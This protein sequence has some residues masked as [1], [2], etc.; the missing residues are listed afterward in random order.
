MT[1]K[2]VILL[3]FLFS[4]FT[5]GSS[6]I[7]VKLKAEREERKIITSKNRD[8]VRHFGTN[9]FVMV[10]T[11]YEGLDAEMR[12]VWVATVYNIAIS[13]QNGNSVEDI[14][15]YQKEFLEILDRMEEYGMNTLFFQV[16]PANDAFYQ[17]NLNPW[18]KFLV[19]EGVEP[20]WDPLRFMI[21]ETHKRGFRFYCWMNAFRVTTESYVTSGKA[22][23]AKFEDIVKMKHEALN[24]LAKDNFARLHPEYVVAG[25]Y[26]EKLILNPSE[27]MV[28][29]FIVDTIME[30]VENYDVDGLHFDDYFYLDG[31]SSS[32]TENTCFVGYNGYTKDGADILNDIPNY[33][34]YQKNPSSYGR[35][36]FGDGGIYGMEAGLNLGD[37]RRENI[38]IMMRN[39]RQKIDA[40]NQRTKKRVEFGTKPA[41]V[42]RSNSEYCTPG[43]SRCV[44]NG[45]NTA[46][47]AYS[48]YNDL[49]ADS[50]KW[51]QEGLVDWVAPQVYYSFEDAYAPYADIVDWWAEQ[52]RIINEKRKQ[53]GKKDIRLY[54]AQGIYK[55][56]DNPDQFYRSAEIIDQLKYNNKY[57]DVLKGSAVYSY[58]I[59]Y[60]TLGSDIVSKYPNAE[61]I[62]K[63]AMKNFKNLWASS[64]VFPLAI[65]ENDATNLVLKEYQIIENSKGMVTI[66]FKTLENAC[67]YGYY[68]VKKGETF[69]SNNLNNRQAVIYAGYEEN[70]VLSVE[71]GELDETFDYYFIPVSVN[72]Y[73]ATK[74]TKIDFSQKE[75]NVAPNQTNLVLELPST[76]EQLVGTTIKGYF[77]KPT[78]NNLDEVS[79]QFQ[80]LE[81]T[82]KRSIDVLTEEKEDRI[83]FYW[84]SYYYETDDLQIILV[85]SDGDLQTECYS[86]KFRLVENYSPSQTEITTDKTEYKVGETIKVNYAPLT[87]YTNLTVYL[88]SKQIKIDITNQYQQTNTGSSFEVKLT[89]ECINNCFIEFQLKNNTKTTICQSPT[90]QVLELP[91]T[92]VEISVSNTNYEGG[93]TISVH[94][95][96]ID[97]GCTVRV[98]L[99]MNSTKQDMTDA[100]NQTKNGTTFIIN[101]P[102]ETGDACY[103]EL[104]ITNQ[105]NSKTF[106]S[107]HFSIEK[108][109]GKNCK[110]CQKN[111]IVIIIQMITFV[112]IGIYAF[113]KRGVL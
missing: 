93:S 49:Y 62:R 67:C 107:P 101:L 69:D 9:Q 98:Y 88:V 47:G 57:Q 109:S 15:T 26:D 51:V 64:P 102:N 18:S 42:W 27:P 4:F 65:G 22:L 91:I 89:G 92:N 25:L 90:F 48:T 50:L 80:L 105:T 68:K 54:I 17:S 83:Y 19:G 87:N 38:N 35:E 29:R 28:Q 12:G 103:I 95:S 78:D 71:I 16:R 32:N 70:K 39:I 108:T 66:K 75:M 55:Y 63:A 58:E 44:E 36:A 94:Y 72:G 3:F 2:I 5:L 79:Y 61:I 111:S 113:R 104:E 8:G 76:N 53:V 33:L 81:G 74:A 112:A 73:P 82:R 84:K 43:S 40:Y 56:R 99:V 52:V 30:I 21:E 85:L 45:S 97:D 96:P 110:K 10:P 13:K 20:G 100:F 23:T 106:I 59:L 7:N 60:K 41:A 46:E 14:Q 37:F 11:E 86:D 1:K 31:A 24:N 6:H 34:E 77:L